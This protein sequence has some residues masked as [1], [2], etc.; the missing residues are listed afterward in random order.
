VTRVVLEGDVA[1]LAG[2][3][4]KDLKM[5]RVEDFLR[6]SLGIGD[7]AWGAEEPEPS[8]TSSGLYERWIFQ[9]KPVVINLPFPGGSAL[10]KGDLWHSFVE[11]GLLQTR[12]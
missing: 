11:K 5:T 9:F 10:I 4:L 6:G 1:E 7:R 3:T 2:P 12:V 8:S